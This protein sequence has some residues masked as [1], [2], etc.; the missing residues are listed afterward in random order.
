[1][2]MLIDVTETNFEVG[3]KVE[4]HFREIEDSVAYLFWYYG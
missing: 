1:M 2:E 3:D 4:V